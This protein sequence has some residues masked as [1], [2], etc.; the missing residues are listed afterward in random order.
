MKCPKCESD[1]YKN[2]NHRGKQR[3]KCKKCKY[4]FVSREGRGKDKQIK[5]AA[6]TLYLYGLSFRAIASYLK[7]SQL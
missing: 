4:Q 7:V 2:E 1:S 5:S 3:Y 6:V